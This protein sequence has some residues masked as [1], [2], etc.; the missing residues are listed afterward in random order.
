MTMSDEFL[1]QSREEPRPEFAA[2]LRQRLQAQEAEPAPRRL[3]WP[4]RPALAAACVLACLGLLLALP[5]VRAAAQGFLDSF[6]VKRFA[7]VPFDPERLARLKEGEPELRRLMASQVEVLQEPGPMREV[8]DLEEAASVTGI[9][10]RVPATVPNGVTGPEVRVGGSGLARVTLDAAKIQAILDAVEVQAELP[11]GLDGTTVTIETPQ[12]VQ[13][14]YR[15]GDDDYITFLQARSPEVTLPPGLDLAELA[16]LGLQVLGLSPAEARSFARTIDWR[17]TLL[18]AVPAEQATYR[19]VELHGTKG[20]LVTTVGGSRPGT[21][22]QRRQSGPRRSVL[23]WS[24]ADMI[25]AMAGRGNGLDLVE[26][27][28][29]M[30]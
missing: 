25:F 29:S 10:V 9:Q 2:A 14:R 6:R 21:Q 7:A 15:R 11:P 4:V 23:L 5:S 30:R 18:I 8:A 26:M 20:L 12:N 28:Q 13:A 24:E 16:V 19:E 1:T 22:G 3:R 27:A 17:S